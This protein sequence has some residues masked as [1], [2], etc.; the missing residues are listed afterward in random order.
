MV[1]IVKLNNQMLSLKIVINDSLAT[2]LLDSGATHSFF[3][4]D[5]CKTNGLKLDSTEHFSVRLADE[6]EVSAVRK[7][8]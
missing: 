6:Q 7:I 1:M 8:K 5:W 3:S 4:A 2:C